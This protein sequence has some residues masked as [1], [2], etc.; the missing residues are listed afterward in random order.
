MPLE[1]IAGLVGFMLTLMIFS[2]LI[3]D[4]PLFRIAVYIFIG[5]SS[6][7][8]AAVVW[9]QVLL[10]KLFAPLQT[11]NTN[12]LL[13]LIVPLLLCISLLA[14]LTPRI[15]WIGNFA[16][17]VL[18]GVG[19]AAALGGAVLGTL[20]PQARA[21]MDAFDFRSAASGAEALGGLFSATVMLA[22]TTV[23]L[24]SFHFSASRAPDGTVKRN[25]ILEVIAWA[26]RIFIAITLGVLFAGV[27]MAA[28]TAMIERLSS[29]INFVRG[30]IGL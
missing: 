4:G 28:L 21:A 25:G 27:Y 8:A 18:V 7:Y 2:Y 16:M 23:T 11:T 15:S 22:G 6:G 3:G 17:A 30:L 10:P 9:H 19:A 13:L 14:K 12:E 26:G 20:I 5:V 24:A 29:T 1:L